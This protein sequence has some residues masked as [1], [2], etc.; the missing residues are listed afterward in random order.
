MEV[1][2]QL[3]A[4]AALPPGKEPLVHIGYKARWTQ[5]RSGGSGEEKNSQSL[6]GLQPPIIQPIVQRY[7]TELFRLLP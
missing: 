6:P 4:P 5:I 7:I 3:H 1:N 2:G